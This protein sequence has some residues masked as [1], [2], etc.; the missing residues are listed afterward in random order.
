[1]FVAFG[2]F[3]VGDQAGVHAEPGLHKDVR[4]TGEDLKDIEG[5]RQPGSSF[6]GGIMGAISTVTKAYELLTGAANA[7]GNLGFDPRLGILLGTPI[8]FVIAF[9]LYEAV[10]G[11]EA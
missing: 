11:R 4:E 1:M 5:D 3:G 2:A 6:T 7:P 9:A 10:R 8:T